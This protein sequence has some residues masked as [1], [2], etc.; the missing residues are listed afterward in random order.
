MA[1]LEKI[2]SKS[3]LLIVIIGVALLAFIIGDFFTSGRTFFGNGTTVAT[4]GDQKIDITDFQR[5]VERF[6][7]NEQQTGRRTDG[8]Q[9]QQQALSDLISERLFNDEIKKLG[10]TVTDAELADFML[11]SGAM[12]LSNR[13]AQE[14]QG[15][16]QS[17]TD[18][19]GMITRPSD[20]GLTPE[21]VR[22]FRDY[23]RQLETETEQQLVQQKYFTLFTGAL[24][25]NELDA[26]AFYDENA[27]PRQMAYVKK[28][29]SA[30]PSD[31]YKP[32]EEEINT[33]WAKHKNAYKIDEQVR[34][35]SYISVAIVPSPEDILAGQQS[36][37]NALAT[38]RSSDQPDALASMPDFVVN[39]ERATKARI[40]NNDVKNFLDTASVGAAAMVSR[41]ANAYTLAKL[42][43][44]TA[45]TD[46][47]NI[48]YLIVTDKAAMDSIM[49]ALRAGASFKDFADN[50]AVAESRDS[51]WVNLTASEMSPLRAQFTE[52][53]TGTWF[54]P[55]TAA[56][57]QGGRIFR[58]NRR[59]APVNV[60]DYAVVNYNIDPSEATVNKLEA[61]LQNFLSE[62]KTS[63]LFEENAIAAGYQVLPAKISASSA[64]IGN[65][66]DSRQAVVWALAADKGQVSP[67]FG[68]ETTGRYLAVALDDIYND[69]IPARDP[70]VHEYLDVRVTGQKKGDA[71]MAQYK[72]KAKDL[73]G[74][75]QLLGTSVDT[76][77]ISFGQVVVPNIGM[78]EA[79]LQARAALA[80]PNKLQEPV[81]GSVAMIV[82]EIVGQDPAVRPYDFNENAQAFNGNRG[83]SR[84][85]N[86][87]TQILQGNKKVKNN[88]HKFYTN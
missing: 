82:F 55:D 35:V 19:H 85:A 3:V 26:K 59:L 45:E 83:S 31:E 72:G 39:Q 61:D 8:A 25:A 4:V 32:T 29:Y 40:R 87:M 84:L 44:R 70:Q 77:R 16:V 33:E 49:T 23:W 64:M 10:I 17:I 2:R 53:A 28:D 5:R 1:T 6:N 79:E 74:Y 73:A 47:A 34:T 50:A 13:V 38:L 9:L 27:T 51:M 54:T 58:V 86:M 88:L 66:N 20:Y 62:N 67:I 56:N 42:Y 11:N 78:G 68:N 80:E 12:M 22:P 36:V 7:A 37:E 30:L 60:Y 46:S 21:Q 75:A 48:D 43:G 18:L 57:A 65:L 15:Q 52:V 76:T 63:A 24:V 81:K 71:L 41:N 14:T 69:F